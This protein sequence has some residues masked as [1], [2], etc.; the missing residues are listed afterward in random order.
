MNAGR[1]QIGE[2]YR[3]ATDGAKAIEPLDAE[4][5][6]MRVVIKERSGTSPDV[7]RMVRAASAA[8][9]SLKPRF[10]VRAPAAA[11]GGGGGGGGGNPMTRAFDLLGGLEASSLAPTEAQQRTLQ[12]LSAEVRDNIAKLNDLISTQMPALRSRLGNLVGA[13]V[14]PVK[15]PPPQ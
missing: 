7:E 6:R 14:A 4:L 5:S 9:D 8:L 2:L 15:K 3:A 13:G 10:G 11:G 12:F 1:M